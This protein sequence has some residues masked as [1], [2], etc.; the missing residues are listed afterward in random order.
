MSKHSE[1]IGSFIRRGNYPIE[2]DY[3]F[4]NEAVLKEFYSDPIQS[5]IL[6]KG[7]LKVVENDGEGNQALYWVTKKQTNDELEFTKLI[8]GN[9]VQTI[10]PQIEELIQRLDNEIKER[11]SGDS[12]I[13]G[14]INPT[15]I[16]EELNSILDLSNA[17][18]DIQEE[19]EALQD[20]A[21][22]GLVEESYY[23][24]DKE[25]LIITFKLNNGNIEKLS[26]PFTNLIREWEP[27][28][29]H[30]S[31]VVEITREEVYSGGADKLSADVRISTK[32]NNI[33]EKDGNSLFVQGTTDNID[34]NGTALSTIIKRLQ[35]RITALEEFIEDCGC[36]DGGGGGGTVITPINILSFTSDITLANELGAT[37]N[38]TFTWAY[39]TSSV[40]S[41]TLN[42]ITVDNGLRTYQLTGISSDTTVKLF[43]SYRGYTASAELK[44]TFAPRVYYGGHSQDNLTNIKELPNTQ[45]GASVDDAK[46]NCEG[47]KY[48]YYAIPSSLK[49]KVIFYVD[50]TN[51]DATVT[52]Y[53]TYNT[54][55]VNANGDSIEYTV[56]KLDNLHNTQFELDIKVD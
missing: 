50:D 43:A 1:I 35:K 39:N 38:P 48:A 26:I 13:W 3:V 10:V 27:D 21:L 33:L 6:H 52:S 8:S 11:Q 19:L 30:P 9:F 54:T 2:A 14:T 53:S 37:I 22:D 34:H 16:P 56:F 15:I 36:G 4:A 7:L 23:D 18:K 32:V 24:A 47:G 49:D 42:N 5:A 25:A 41:Q 28:N 12:A 20:G 40:D 51:P 44:F 45:L 29:S 17:V 55:I 31:K 46:F